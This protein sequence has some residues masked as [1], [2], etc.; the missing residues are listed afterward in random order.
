MLAEF[1][2]PSFGR[3]ELKYTETNWNGFV[4]LEA[5]SNYK[6]MG[7]THFQSLWVNDPY[8]AL[9]T[10]PWFPPQGTLP[11]AKHPDGACFPGSRLTFANF[12]GDGTSHTIMAV[13]TTEPILSHWALGW[14]Q[15][16]VALP[17]RIPGWTPPD[18]VTFT[19]SPV[20]PSGFANDYSRYWHPTG[21]TGTFDDE[22]STMPPEFRTF[23]SHEVETMGW[24]FP[25]NQTIVSRWLVNGQQYGPDSQHPKV[26]NHLMV[27]GSVHNIN[28]QID[29][30]A[31]MFLVTRES[32]DP[33]PRME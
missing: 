4:M 6:V 15:S 32:G 12:K 10:S 26:T 27:D 21:F 5:I 13:E 3:N 25:A 16:V 18:A 23:L 29:V 11:T 9:H 2:C 8:F 30:A 14:E 17:T 33:A 7:A 20:P 1:I 28:K 19:N 31:Y 24:Y 22:S